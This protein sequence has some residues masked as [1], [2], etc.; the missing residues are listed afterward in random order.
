MSKDDDIIEEGKPISLLQNLCIHTMQTHEFTRENHDF[1]LKRGQNKQT[2]DKMET[3][4]MGK[5]STRRRVNM[6]RQQDE[7]DARVH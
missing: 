4:W 1:A 6:P 5:I 7:F 2:S 3:V